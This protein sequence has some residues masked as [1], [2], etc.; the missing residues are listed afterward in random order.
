M[1]R[2]FLTTFFIIYTVVLLTQQC[3][4]F[5]AA[6]LEI[7]RQITV[8]A[9]SDPIRS[10]TEPEFETCS[11]FCICGC[12]GL[13]VLHHGLTTVVLTDGLTVT[14]TKLLPFYEAPSSGSHADSI[15]QP[16]KV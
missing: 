1:H 11:P 10:D 5:Q 12:C 8:T 9:I 15:W 6:S 7:N 16:P 2:K 3:E 14:E 13:S 4:D